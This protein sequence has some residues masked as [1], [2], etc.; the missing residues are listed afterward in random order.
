MTSYTGK[1]TK[2][3]HFIP[4]YLDSLRVDTVLE[5]DLYLKVNNRLVLY[6]S[7]DLSF[8]DR[9]RQK[10]LENKVE[11]LYITGESKPKYQRYMERNLSN[12]LRDPYIQEE[13]KAGILYEASTNLIREVLANP[14]YGENIRRSKDLVTNTVEFILKGRNAFLSLLKITSFDYYTYTHSVNVCTFSVALARQTGHN[15]EQF[16][17]ELGVGALLHDVGKSRVEERILKKHS[18]LTPTEF[19]VVK[20]HPK[21]GVDIL[22][23]TDEVVPASFYPVLQ[24]HERGNR[25]GYPSGLSLDEMH[26]YSKLVAIADSFDA[27]TTHRVYQ[28]AIES[29]PALRTMLSM[30]DAFDDALLRAFIELMGPCGLAD[31]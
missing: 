10:L 29:F 5:F 9:T 27:M 14:A 6:R 17:N 13:S 24:H 2:E 18:V 15:D 25:R 20:R 4:I 31:V 26:L 12:V 1:T 23:E 11:R 19:E 16:L 21:W 30:K 22:T 8:T 3:R 7:A 28:K